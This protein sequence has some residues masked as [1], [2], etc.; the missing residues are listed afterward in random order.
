MLFGLAR[1]TFQNLL[2]SREGFQ[3][4]NENLAL[5]LALVL[6]LLLLL[7]VARFLWND[8]LVNVVTFAKPI[9]ELWQIFG[10]VLLF[11]IMCP[12]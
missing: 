5:F 6:W 1:E 11:D 12:K 8:V 2:S 4:D 7:V 9:K 10:L 3:Q